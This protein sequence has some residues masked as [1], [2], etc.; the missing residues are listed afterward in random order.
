MQNVQTKL[1]D[2]VINNVGPELQQAMGIDMEQFAQQKE[3]QYGFVFQ[4]L[5]GCASEE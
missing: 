2:M 4:P 5:A 3:G 1:H